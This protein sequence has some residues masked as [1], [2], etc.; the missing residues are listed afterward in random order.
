MKK[1]VKYLWTPNY[2]DSKPDNNFCCESFDVTF[3]DIDFT[4][5]EYL[6]NLGVIVDPD[7]NCDSFLWVIENGEKTGEAYNI[8]SEQII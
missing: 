3:D 2:D 1:L 5:R 6:E 8:I 7:D 4:M